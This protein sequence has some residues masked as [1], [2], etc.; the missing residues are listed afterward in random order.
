MA[1]VKCSICKIQLCTTWIIFNKC[2]HLKS[3]QIDV[4]LTTRRVQ[5]S[6]VCLDRD[7]WITLYFSKAITLV[8]CKD[9]VWMKKHRGRW[10]VKIA[11]P[12]WSIMTLLNAKSNWPFNYQNNN[13][14]EVH[15]K[16]IMTIMLCLKD[17]KFNLNHCCRIM[18]FQTV[19]RR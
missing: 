14:R 2:W 9:L 15:L 11:T 10:A 7:K 16:I 3:N 5:V 19:K 17:K 4:T 1:M 12:I 13:L 18:W 8:F 6:I